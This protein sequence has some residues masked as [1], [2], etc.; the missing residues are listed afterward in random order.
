M[1]F[2]KCN[3][4]VGVLTVLSTG[5]VF[6]NITSRSSCIRSILSRSGGESGSSGELGLRGEYCFLLQYINKLTFY[7]S[8]P[9]EIF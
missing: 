9:L 6:G 5:G 3:K 1:E 8:K 4:F 2:I 7:F